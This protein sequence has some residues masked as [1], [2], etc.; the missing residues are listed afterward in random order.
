MNC[1]KCGN[2]FGE[3]EKFCRKCGADVDRAQLQPA[4][5][6]RIANTSANNSVMNS[7]MKDPDELAG[8]GVASVMMGD[9]FFIV[10]VLLTFMNSSVSSFLWLLLLIP[11]FFF[12]G[13]GFS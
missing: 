11:A 1:V 5:N 3:G 4:T 6:T 2:D 9:G 10:A 8:N 12:F 7:S 13:K